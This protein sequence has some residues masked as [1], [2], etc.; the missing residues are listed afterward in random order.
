MSSMAEVPL[1][2]NSLGVAGFVHAV[3]GE[4]NAVVS[5]NPGGSSVPGAPDLGNVASNAGEDIA[6]AKKVKGKKKATDEGASSKQLVTEKKCSGSG[7]LLG[8]VLK[9]DSEEKDESSYDFVDY[10][11]VDPSIMETTSVYRSS[12]ET[13]A[14]TEEYDFVRKDFE[15]TAAFYKGQDGSNL[16]P[17]YWSPRPNS[18][19]DVDPNY[20]SESNLA[21]IHYLAVEDLEKSEQVEIPKED[22]P[23]D[24]AEGD[25]RKRKRGKSLEESEVHNISDDENRVGNIVD[26]FQEFTGSSP[27]IRSLWDSRFEFGNMIDAECSLPGDQS[28]LD[29]WGPRSAHVMLQIQGIRSAFL[30]RY[31]EL[32]HVKGLFEIDSLQKKV[33]SLEKDLSGVEELRTKV[34]G[35]EGRVALLN[36][37]KHDLIQKNKYFSDELSQLK[38]DKETAEAALLRERNDHESTKSKF[39]ADRDQLTAEAADSYDSGF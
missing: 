10:S 21:E 18:I 13:V 1:E 9:V 3:E 8:Y 11:W 30:G 15:G 33:T 34:A 36:Q 25:S 38:S 12:E 39:A 26:V 35:L 7:P 4:G 5:A 24:T 20:F 23:L 27:E 28:Q 6:P 14:F 19:L 16:F 22:H 29:K 2:G 31:L 37:E 32:Q 17:L